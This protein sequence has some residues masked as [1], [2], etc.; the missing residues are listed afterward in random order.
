[1]NRADTYRHTSKSLHYEAPRHREVFVFSADHAVL[2]ADACDGPDA[3]VPQLPNRP[4]VRISA[5]APSTASLREVKN[6]HSEPPGNKAV[7]S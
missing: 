4:G 1:M 5:Q 3:L 6:A 2:E 7:E